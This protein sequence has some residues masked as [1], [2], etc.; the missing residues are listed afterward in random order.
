MTTPLMT[1]VLLV[2][3]ALAVGRTCR[4]ALALRW[5][6][7]RLRARPAPA[8]PPGEPFV[9][10]LPAFRE[11]SLVK[12]TV[13]Y[14]QSLDHPVEEYRVVVVTSAR[15]R[16]ERERLRGTLDAFAEKAFDLPEGRSREELLTGHLPGALIPGL[17][18]R[19]TRMDRAAFVA[20]VRELFDLQ[21]TTGRMVDQLV[22]THLAPDLVRQL[23][24]PADRAGKAG[25]LA[26]ALEELDSALA[27]WPRIT[28]CRYVV[29]YDFDA[30][31][32][33]DVLRVAASAVGDE[34]LLLQQS[35]FVLPRTGREVPLSAGLFTLMDSQLH[36]RFG[37]RTELASLLLDRRFQSLPPR[38]AV[39]VRSSIHAVGNGL[40]LN[41]HRLPEL[42]GIPT[43]VDDLSLGWRAAAVGA[44]FHPVGSPVWYDGY[45]TL[46]QAAA[47]R[48]F[49]CHGYQSAA[50]EIR[51]TPGFSKGVLPVQLVK[52]HS[53]TV[54]WTVGPFVRVGILL[55]GAVTVPFVALAAAC[56]TYGLYVVDTLLV[57]RLWSW[58]GRLPEESRWVVASAVLLGP[59]ALFWYGTGA[60]AGL[61]SS[62]LG[63]PAWAVG[64][65]ER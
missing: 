2:V 58:S 52:I 21:E 47:S 45:P 23:E 42:G 10:L 8:P 46:A 56:L 32:A 55:A 9:I 14:F 31:P 20:H 13:E 59:V 36:A 1:G 18:A 24:A 44:S 7:G 34:A 4:T 29:V 60:R 51:R 65:T 48:R 16:D 3:T 17:L 25:Q 6:R 28:D 61:L 12:E 11:Q 30:R 43:S 57:R 40:F 5:L 26:Y 64:K 19:R 38:L 39:L 50:R 41:R 62:W 54:Q 22:S 49:I 35:A 15:E 33:K 37:L 63:R 27:D 53:R